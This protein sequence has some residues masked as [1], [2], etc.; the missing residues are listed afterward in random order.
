[1]TTKRVYK[2]A[3]SVEKAVEILEE[4]RGTPF[5]PELIEIFLSNMDKVLEI[6][7]AFPDE[8]SNPPY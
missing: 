2:P 4:G 7:Q 3:F 8:S 6:R 1:L 5:D